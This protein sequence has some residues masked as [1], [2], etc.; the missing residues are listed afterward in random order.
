MTA[1]TAAMRTP[2]LMAPFSSA[3]VCVGRAGTLL[4]T[5]A[6]REVEALVS[7]VGEGVADPTKTESEVGGS[8][9]GSNVVSVVG[10]GSEV[11]GSAVSGVPGP[12][13]SAVG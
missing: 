1:T 13:T 9:T 11:V 4:D 6:R 8:T 10:S 12:V 5:V 2:F 7:M 3:F